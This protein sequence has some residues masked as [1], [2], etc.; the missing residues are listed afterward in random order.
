MV[1]PLLSFDFGQ[2][3]PP[4]LRGAGVTVTLV[5][6]AG[7]AGTIIGLV[8]G[9]A[10]SAP[11]APIRWLA[12]VYI[13][14]LRGIPILIILL[15]L[16][17]EIP[18]LFP[19]ATFSQTLTAVIGLSVYAGA[20]MAEIFRGSI[21]AIPRGQLE[22]GEALGLNYLQKMRYVVLPQAM[23]IAVP[24]GIGFLIAL[25]KASSLVSVISATDLTRAGR[26]ITSQNH[27][28][29][30]TFLVVAALYFVISYPLSLFGRWYERRLA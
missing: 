14:F 4:M 12:S 27:A 7:V 13:N 3:L 17:Y 8:F 9:V 6:A 21:Q 15:F 29:L 10:R 1:T 30:S 19:Y 22:A 23:K 24:P 16:Y 20:Y 5:L 26:I 28:P 18:L 25:V 2:F 11:L